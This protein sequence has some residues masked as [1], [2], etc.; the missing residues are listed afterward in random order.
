MN[1]NKIK[2][3]VGDILPCRWVLFVLHV[4]KNKRTQHAKW[5][6]EV[7]LSLKIAKK[8]ILTRRKR[9]F[10][11]PDKINRNQVSKN[12]PFSFYLSDHHTI[13]PSQR[14]PFSSDERE[15]LMERKRKER[16]TINKILNFQ[17]SIS[18]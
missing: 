6:M 5:W 8:V 3:F 15:D 10:M 1:K 12:I 14:N 9:R 17:I 2:S 13:T 18:L 16:K 11:F 7:N 4:L